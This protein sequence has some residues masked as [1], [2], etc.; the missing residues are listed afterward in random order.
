MKIIYLHQ[1]F[2]TPKMSG[3]VRSYD[4]A[5]H[6]VDNGHTVEMVTTNR[7]LSDSR[8][9]EFSNEDGIYVHWFS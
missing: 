1:Y 9:W 4:I 8:G 5:K 6:L 2:N 7:V 3:G